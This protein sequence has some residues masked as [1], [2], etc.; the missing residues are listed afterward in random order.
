VTKAVEL[1]TALWGG[2]F[3]VL[4]PASPESSSQR[5]QMLRRFEPD[6]LVTSNESL[7]PPAARSR[8][9]YTTFDELLFS[10]TKPGSFSACGLNVNRHFY[11]LYIRELRFQPREASSDL[12]LSKFSDPGLAAASAVLW[13]RF[14]SIAACEYFEEAFVS[15]LV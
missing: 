12:A 8:R 1:C 5:D 4:I 9:D 13:G 6:Y 11:D 7:L 14:P 3:N 2:V 10:F 15:K